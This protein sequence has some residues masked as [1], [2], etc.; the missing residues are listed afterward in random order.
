MPVL[1]C[2]AYLAPRLA[3]RALPLLAALA[4]A[5]LCY[6]F[7]HAYYARTEPWRDFYEY[8]GVRAQFT[9][10]DRVQPG[11]EVERALRTV[12]WERIDLG[13]LKNWFFA[14][15]SRFSLSNLRRILDEVPRRTPRLESVAAS[16]VRQIP[17]NTE[18]CRLVLAG[19]CM[20]LIT[21]GSWRGLTLPVALFGMA[22]V[23]AVCL[24]AWFWITPRIVYCLLLGV[25]T[26]SAF[27]IPSREKES[28]GFWP[29]V[30]NLRAVVRS[31]A[32][33]GGLVLT[34]WTLADAFRQDAYRRAQRLDSER[35]IREL[36]PQPDQLFVVW[37]EWFP[38]RQLV[39]PLA[40]PA[41][42]R[43]FRC[44]A[45]SWLIPTPYT[46][47]RCRE[48]H[49]TDIHRA[50]W[51]RADVFLAADDNLVGLLRFYAARH[52]RKAVEFRPVFEY[53]TFRVYQGHAAAESRPAV[54]TPNE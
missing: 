14:D 16:L 23:V 8:N 46:E 50:L 44:V 39:P 6:K 37:A 34:V 40:D 53:S 35:L 20:A 18:L 45:L 5:A 41:L 11:P 7:N 52:Y 21:A 9:D 47:A 2:V 26:L 48:Y 36:N 32:V 54:P 29:R 12:G 25:M 10:Y 15:R 38:F 3:R 4:I 49:I 24:G 51:E 19:C 33:V 43:D 22:F 17:E 42:L 27:P 13:M 28:F 31:L 1:A 30:R